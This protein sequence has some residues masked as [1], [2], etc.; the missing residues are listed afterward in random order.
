MRALTGI[1]SGF[2]STAMA[3]VASQVPRDRL[4]FALGWLSTGQIAGT[5]LGPLFGGL[6]ADRLHDF[7]VVFFVSAFGTAVIGAGCAALVDERRRP[8]PEGGR[9]RLPFFE[10]MQ[11]ILQRPGLAPMLL[12][13][14]LAQISAIGVSSVLPLFI[15][16]IVGNVSWLGTATGAAF[17][18]T[19]VAGLMTAPFLGRM[20]DR[21]G[22]R[23]VLLVAI[24][25]AAAFTLPQALATSIWAVLGLRFGL[26]IFLGGILPARTPPSATSSARAN[27]AKSTA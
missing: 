16:H 11:N 4:G 20:G 17:A 12:V 25:G 2:S 18:V 8:E 15:A 26:G 24:A 22:Y 10:N 23:P 3:L 1:F 9:E 5:L 21:I 14:M 7:R 19:G 6:L 27:G 13:L